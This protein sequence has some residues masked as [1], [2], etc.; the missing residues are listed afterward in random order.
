MA[1]RH[2]NRE[3]FNAL[4]HELMVGSSYN[5]TKREDVCYLLATWIDKGKHFADLSI[6][7]HYGQ[8]ND[9]KLRSG[10]AWHKDAE[11]SLLHFAVTLRGERV[12][13]SKRIHEISLREGNPEPTEVLE[14]QI[15][16]SIYLSS[17]TLMY[18]APQFFDTNYDSRVIA[19]H[20]RI[21]YTNAEI[22]H[23]RS[24]RTR[25]SWEKLTSILADT[26]S[27]AQLQLPTLEQVEFH[28]GHLT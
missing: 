11:N 20:A 23:F 16:G 19:I 27:R 9:S 12:L 21:L 25:D 6:Q 5:S 2:I 18:H 3:I 15:P 10:A 14:K 1:F 28:M 17:S 24:V 13:H 7:I 4:K 8:G 22:D 26:L